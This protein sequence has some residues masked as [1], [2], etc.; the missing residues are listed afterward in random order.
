MLRLDTFDQRLAVIEIT[1]IGRFEMDSAIDSRTLIALFITCGQIDGDD[2]P[3]CVGELTTD[4][5]T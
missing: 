2:A 3:A 4:F 1:D 5:G